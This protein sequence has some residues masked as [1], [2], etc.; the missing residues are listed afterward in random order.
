VITGA[1]TT[2]GK[3]GADMPANG[4][5]VAVR[6]ASGTDSSDSGSSLHV[7]G[8]FG[9]L[10]ID[11]HGNYKYVADGHAPQNFRDLFQY[12]LA[13][14]KG[15][16]SVAELVISRGGEIQVSENA[17]KVVPNPDGTITLPAG[18]DLNDVHVVGRDL[19]VTMPDGSQIVIVDGAVFVPQLVIGGVEVPSTN[20]AA[21]LI[22]AEPKPG[23]GNPQSSGGNFEVPVGP[24]DPGVPLGDLIPPTELH[25]TPPEFQPIYP[26]L[27]NHEP[28][29]EIQPDGQPAAINAEDSVN[30]K[31]LPARNEGEPAGSGEIADGNGSNNSDP[32][33]ATS[34]TIVISSQ[35]GVGSVTINGVVVNLA[36]PGQVIHGAY[37][38]LTIT[39]FNGQNILYTYTLTDNTHGD[40]THDDFSVTVTDSDGDHATA[41]LVVDIIDDVP[42][43]RP[44]TDSVAA[45]TYGPETGNVMTGAGT[46]SGTPGADTVGADDAHLSNVTGHGSTT[47]G[48]GSWTVQGQYGVLTIDENGNYSYTRNPGTP[49]GVS[50]VFNYTLTDGDG[51]SSTTT[52]TINIGNNVPQTGENGVV[53]L[54]DDALAGGNPGGVG[55]D[56]DSVNATGTLSGS[57]GDGALTFAVQTSGAPSG[58]TYVSGG[59]GVVLV[60]QD[61]HTVLTVTVGSDGS[62]S[63]VQNAAIDHAAGGN[64]NNAIFTINYTVSDADGDSANGSFNINVDDDTPVVTLADRGTPRGWWCT[65]MFKQTLAR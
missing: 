22:D 47:T 63:V 64:E 28:T 52:L 62:Y 40:G 31:G 5:V 54:D 17:Q 18:V 56:P 38:D 25:F 27:V 42:T 33:E 61:G 57:G 36:S 32:S 29:I 2:T 30:E 12:T 45:G 44:D 51:D 14:S 59:A 35:D 24:L 39:G 21:L 26:G 55:D 60:Q 15:G 1:G 13:D 23:A 8:R 34:G 65:V 4:H 16:R 50:D 58:F 37:G 20:L 19:I 3:A 41:T 53:Q 46:T 43:T 9:T 49:G 48:E 11:E 7:D 10:A 6:G